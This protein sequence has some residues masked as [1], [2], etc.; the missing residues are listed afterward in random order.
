MA[1]LFVWHYHAALCRLW[2]ESIRSSLDRGRLDV[3]VYRSWPGRDRWGGIWLDADLVVS[4]YRYRGFK[5]L[6]NFQCAIPGGSVLH[7]NHS[8]LCFLLDQWGG[9]LVAR[10]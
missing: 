4:V 2:L 5:R 10:L 6:C 1:G 8:P 9:L 7:R 3:R